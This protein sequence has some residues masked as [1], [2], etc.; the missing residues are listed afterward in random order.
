MQIGDKS[1]KRQQTHTI[2]WHDVMVILFWRCRVSLVRFSYCSKFHN[3]TT[4]GSGVMIIFVYKGFTRNPE[5]GNTLVWVLSNIWRLRRARETKFDTNISNKK[6]LNA[7][8]FQ[9]Y[10][11]YRFWVI[12]AK[13][14]GGRIIT[15]TTPLPH[16]TTHIHTQ[17]RVK[18][19]NCMLYI[20]LSV[21]FE[22]L[23]TDREIFPKQPLEV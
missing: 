7:S 18:T 12:K 14:T 16:P 4:T 20:G 19:D 5:I 22:L 11:F 17:I 10:S 3:N 2:C 23:K 1:E 15:T 8:K 13:P 6:L 21:L 9:G